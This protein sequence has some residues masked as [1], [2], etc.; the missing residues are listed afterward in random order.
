MKKG[1]IAFSILMTGMFCG[2]VLFILTFSREIA[3]YINSNADN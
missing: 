3:T 1:M 2:M